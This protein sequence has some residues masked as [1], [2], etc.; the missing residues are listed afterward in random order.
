MSRKALPY[1]PNDKASSKVDLPAPFSPTINVVAWESRTTVVGKFPVL[2][3]FDQVIDL[4]FI[5]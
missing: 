5:I 2:R 4:K 3:K 1:K